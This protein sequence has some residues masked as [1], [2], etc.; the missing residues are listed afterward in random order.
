MNANRRTMLLG[1]VLGMLCLSV[2]AA[3]KGTYYT[4]V[5]IWYEHPEKIFSTNYH[6]GSILPAGTKVEVLSARRKSV[7]FRVEGKDADYLFTYVKKHSSLGFDE[8]FDRLFSREN[9]FFELAKKF[10]RAEKEAVEEGTVVVGMSREA[11]LT[12]YGYPPS[13]KTPDLDSD[14]WVYWVKR[15]ST[16]E[17]FFENGKVAKVQ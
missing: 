13:H 8:E 4:R 9:H 15:M 7:R 17:L 14:H 16:K 3:N 11:V 10:T 6:A 12:A 1:L 5:N 2:L